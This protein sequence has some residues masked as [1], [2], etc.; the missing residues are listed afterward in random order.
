MPL[1]A[2]IFNALCKVNYAVHTVIEKRPSAAKRGYGRRWRKESKLF[3]A[4]PEN[5]L[6]ATCK[7]EGRVRASTCVDHIIPVSGS[8]D[9]K[10]WD[11]TK[12]QGSCTEC[13]NKKTAT[14]DG[15]FGNVKK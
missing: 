8:G 12:W 14:E 1:K 5:A 3:L 9:P 4:M 11:K 10:F 7:K 2:P 6:C 15:G 13:H